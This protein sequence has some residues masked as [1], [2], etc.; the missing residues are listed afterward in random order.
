MTP[1]EIRL[2]LYKRRKV[3]SQASIARGLGVTKQAVYMA[4]DRKMT[5]HR[6]REGIASAI[7]R[8]LTDVFPEEAQ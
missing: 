3:V 4:I 6:V 5:S 8:Q 1:E 7:G 2:E